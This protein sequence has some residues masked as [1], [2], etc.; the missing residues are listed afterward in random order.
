[1]LAASEELDPPPV[2]SSSTNSEEKKDS[3]SDDQRQHPHGSSCT[4][5][6]THHNSSSSCSPATPQEMSSNRHI[7]QQSDEHNRSNLDRVVGDIMKSESSL[8]DVDYMHIMQNR[9]TSHDQMTSMPLHLQFGRNSTQTAERH[10]S[11][12]SLQPPTPAPARRTRSSN[13]G[14]IKCQFC[15]KKWSNEH[16]LRA[17]MTD[18]RLLR[19]HECAQCG[20]RFKARGG[21]QQHMRIHSTEKLYG[22]TYCVK[23]FTQKSHLDQHERIH[24]GAKPFSC[25]FCGRAFRQRSQQIGHESTHAPHSTTNTNASVS[26]AGNTAPRTPRKKR[27]NASSEFKQSQNSPPPNLN[28]LDVAAA[29]AMMQQNHLTHDILGHLDHQRSDSLL[30]LSSQNQS[31]IS[32]LL[33]LQHDITHQQPQQHHLLHHSHLSSQ[34]LH[35][36]G[37]SVA[38]P[39]GMQ[40]INGLH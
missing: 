8:L 13:D 26:S 32:S 16:A 14:M 36:F 10:H 18:C 29:A 12:E 30:A 25:Q 4:S 22:C 33:G 24:T 40:L 11:A 21:L 19:S 6:N 17:H 9:L 35:D 38:T 3:I 28:H 1:M 20:K 5:S 34:Q 27:Q 2:S 37:A 39:S 23:R 31:S 7:Q 15:P